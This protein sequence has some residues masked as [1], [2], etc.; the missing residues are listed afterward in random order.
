[1]RLDDR[2]AITVTRADGL[3]RRWGPDEPEYENLV[4]GLE[5]TTSIPGGNKTA[6]CDLLRRINLDYPDLGLFDDFR[7]YGAGNET[8]WEGRMQSLPRDQG[9]GFSIVPAAVGWAAHLSDD[10]SFAEIYIDRDFS[11]WGGASAQ[12]RFNALGAYTIGDPQIVQDTSTGQAALQLAAQGEWTAATKPLIEALYDGHGVP[13]GWIYYAWK[14]GSTINPADTNWRWQLHASDDDVIAGSLD[15]T[16]NLRGA[17]PGAN[18][19][20]IGASRRFAVAQLAYDAGPAGS[21]NASFP[22]LFTCLAVYGRHGLTPHGVDSATSARGFYASDV[23]RDAVGRA[24]PLLTANRV[25]DTTFAIPH[26]VFAD[27]TTAEDVVLR[28]N[29]YHLFKWGVYDDRDFFWQPW[30]AEQDTVWEARISDGAQ[31]SLAGDD[32]EEIFNGVLVSFTDPGGRRRLVGPPGTI[33]DATGATL[34]DTRPENPVNAHGIPRRYGKLEISTITT[35]AAAIQL[36]ATWL[37]ERSRHQR[38]GSLTI[39]SRIRHPAGHWRPAWAPRAG[40]WVRIPDHAFPGPRR[41]T[42]TRYS[43]DHRT[44]AMTLD[45]SSFKLDAILERMGVAL[46]G[47]LT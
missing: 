6:K 17:G 11:R 18:A 33:A 12:R 7:V 9:A 3:S 30:D 16:A 32:A 1:M 38:R 46:V 47:V 2:L 14:I 5:L 26:L 27:P 25:K 45:N 20:T 42:E 8:A 44:M 34:A 23:I 39:T 4:A 35:Q 43:H 40:D 15:S 22:L 13:L 29:G 19:I 36:G 31:L 24:A 10:P 21:D 41:I 28:C 37:A